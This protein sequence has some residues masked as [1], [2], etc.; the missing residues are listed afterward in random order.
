[1]AEGD[2]AEIKNELRHSARLMAQ[3]GDRT[4]SA[5]T[6]EKMDNNNT[7]SGASL[8]NDGIRVSGSSSD[9]KISRTIKVIVCNEEVITMANDKLFN[10]ETQKLAD[11]TYAMLVH[12]IEV[13]NNRDIDPGPEWYLEPQGA[14][15][16]ASSKELQDGLEASK[17]EID[18]LRNE[19][20]TDSQ[21]LMLDLIDKSKGYQYGKR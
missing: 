14:A 21:S 3:L 9:R 13:F 2:V 4:T 16:G 7:K 18:A 5:D 10:V 15:N 6:S 11:K 17:E 1:M 20:I 19:A 8:V 12:S